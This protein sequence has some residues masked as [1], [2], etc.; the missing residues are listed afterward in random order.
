MIARPSE[1]SLRAAR[2]AWIAARVPCQQTG[3]YRFGNAVVDDWEGK[4]NAWP[5]DE[6]LIDYV[7]SS[8]YGSESDEN[9]IYTA[10]V[11]ANA[12]LMVNGECVDA[13]QISRA[14]LAELLHEAEEVE[15][16]VAA[17]W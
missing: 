14:L 10:N 12:K 11:V 15:A 9:P 1:A 17:G 7:D 4:V 13:S 6:G 3:V 16:N 2:Q 8:S 5:L